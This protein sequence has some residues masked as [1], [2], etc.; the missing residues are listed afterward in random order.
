MKI[1]ILYVSAIVFSLWI[2]GSCNSTGYEIEEVDDYSDS[3]IIASKNEI[4]QEVEQP[5]IEIIT[6]PAIKNETESTENKTAPQLFI[7]QFGA[8]VYESNALSYTRKI[9]DVLK[10]NVYCNLINGMY[11]VRTDKFNSRNEADLVLAKVKELGYEGFIT[12][13]VK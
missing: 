2:F 1:K 3:S 10:I 11:K 12:D 5:K 4:K 8:F 13:P 7:V 6:D 9:K